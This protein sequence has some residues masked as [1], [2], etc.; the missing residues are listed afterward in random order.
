MTIYTQQFEYA[1]LCVYKLFFP[2]EPVKFQERTG[3][4]EKNTDAENYIDVSMDLE[5]RVLVSVDGCVEQKQAALEKGTKK[6]ELAACR[7][8]FELLCE[9]CEIRP[10]W[11]IATGIRPV[12]LLHSL[13]EKHTEKDDVWRILQNDYLIEPKKIDLLFEISR[14]QR[15]ILNRQDENSV[16]LYIGIP[17]CPSRCSYCSFVSQAVESKNAVA[18]MQKYIDALCEELKVIAKSIRENRLKLCT[19]Y[20]GGGTPTALS[21]KQLELVLSTVLK[22]F[23]L[24][25]VLEYTVEAGRA[26]TITQEKLNCILSG[27]A[28]ESV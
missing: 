17:F 1:L 22:N 8:L 14:I 3:E 2:F 21:A 11:G 19:V 5:I 16:S 20:I 28:T 6:L 26:D 23:D 15:E 9:V 25:G 27:G 24:S 18:L 10:K 12:K 7:V 4:I 13:Q